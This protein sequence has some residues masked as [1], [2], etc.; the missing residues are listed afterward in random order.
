MALATDFTNATGSIGTRVAL[1]GETMVRN[2]RQRRA[3]KRTWRELSNLNDRQLDD[4]GLSRSEIRRV[5]LQAS[6]NM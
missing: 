2:F 3:F 5:A 6:S 1:W 4:L